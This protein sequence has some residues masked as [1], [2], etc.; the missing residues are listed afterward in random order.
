MKHRRG[1]ERRE[2]PTVNSV[3]A[4]LPLAVNRRGVTDA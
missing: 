2:G 4:F 1:E 3:L